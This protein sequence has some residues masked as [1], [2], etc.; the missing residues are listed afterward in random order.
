VAPLRDPVDAERRVSDQ[1]V[2]LV[3]VVFGFVLAQSLGLYST[4]VLRPWRD[5]NRL[6]AL[7]LLGVYVTTIM[8][9]IDWHRTVARRP[10]DF[11]ERHGV[12]VAERLR[13]GADLFV[14][15]VYAF[16]LFAVDELAA[17]GASLY[18]F[19]YVAMFA[20]YVASG[21]LRRR[22]YGPVASNLTPIVI[23]GVA[24][25][26]AWI[27]LLVFEANDWASRPGRA[28][29]GVIVAILAMGGFRA[30]HTHERVRWR[31]RH[32]GDP[33]AG[34]TVDSS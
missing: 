5:G 1:L 9:W 32:A 17:A 24:T 13:F 2:R 7:A 27:V 20:G 34:S 26:G 6:T 25:L 31:A 33:A 11:G 19:G 15:S 18:V 29:A 21:W 22:T 10:Y 30:V 28:W 4:V 8:S 16:T 12:R 3:Q 23:F 14:V